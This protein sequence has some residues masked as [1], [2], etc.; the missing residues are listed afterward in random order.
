MDR[1]SS[2][3]HII[4]SISSISS[5]GCSDI[6][7]LQSLAHKAG[8]RE[9]AQEESGDVKSQNKKDPSERYR[10]ERSTYSDRSS[11]IIYLINLQEVWTGNITGTDQDCW[12]KFEFFESK[13]IILEGN[14][15]LSEIKKASWNLPLFSFLFWLKTRSWDLFIWVF[16]PHIQYRILSVQIVQ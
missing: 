4:L 15:T 14:R 5:L 9:I 16:L 3:Y 8:L 12:T 7:F 13:R 1:L 10:L 11:S 2:S 6:E